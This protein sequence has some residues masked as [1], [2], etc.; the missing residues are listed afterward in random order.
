M[1][2]M[3]YNQIIVTVLGI[4]LIG[5]IYW[6]FLGKKVD[7]VATEN[8]QIDIEVQGGYSPES[9]KVKK[10]Q[11]TTINFVRKDPSECL[12][13]VVLADF[14]IRQFLPLNKKTSITI[15]P[16]ETG[17]FTFSCG[18]NMNHGTIE[19]VE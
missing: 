4:G 6:F 11:P 16:K 5:L 17:K 13:E 14:N 15:T 10:D 3:A 9:I 1:V 2:F 8:D 19:V 12:E 18:M 7:V